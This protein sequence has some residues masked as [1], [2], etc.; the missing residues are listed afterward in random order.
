MGKNG[1]FSA[2][3]CMVHQL[4]ARKGDTCNHAFT[5]LTGVNYA[6]LHMIQAL[7][8]QALDAPELIDGFY[9]NILDW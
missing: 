5:I 4:T 9:I 7:V 3:R 1:L 6:D 8:M 2:L